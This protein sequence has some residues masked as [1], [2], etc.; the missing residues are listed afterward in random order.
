MKPHFFKT[1]KDFRKWLEKNHATEK[2]ILVGYYNL[3]S[4]KQSITWSES[5]DQA[6]CFGW[7]DGIRRKIDE[8]S[9]CNRF[10][11]RRKNSNWSDININKAKTLIQSGEMT[12]AGL[13]EFENRT[14]INSER[15]PEDAVPAQLSAVYEKVFRKNK[16]AWNFF[17]KQPP[18]HK[19]V[20]IHWIMSAKQEKTQ[21]SRLE[22]AIESCSKEQRL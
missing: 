16:K 10:T 19:K 11:P 8:D 14:K 3:K 9:Y 15:K 2:E 4:K 1:A 22:R 21:I 5:V 17:L 20:I 13:K 18:S 7:I 6:I 12:D